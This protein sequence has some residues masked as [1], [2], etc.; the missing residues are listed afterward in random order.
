MTEP[1]AFEPG[2][3]VAGRYVL[4]EVIGSGGM[5]VVYRATQTALDREV[6]IKLVRPEQAASEAARRRFLREA[7]VAASLDHPGAVR[8]HDFGEHENTLYIVMEMLHGVPLRALVDR[9]RPPLEPRRA[10]H[11][12]AEIADVLASAASIDLVHR[13]L[14]PEN[15]ILE[16]VEGSA[17]RVVVVDFGLAFRAEHTPETGRITVEGMASGTPDYMSPEQVRGQ[18]CGPAADVYALGCVLY[19]MLTSHS[20]L[21]TANPALTLT[22]HLFTS[23]RP[24]REAFPELGVP[25]IVDDLVMA[26]L[27][28]VPSERPSAATVRDVLRRAASGPEERLGGHSAEGR[29]LGRVARMLSERPTMSVPAPT[30]G[31]TE[32]RPMRHLRLVGGELDLEV[33]TGLLANGF[34]LATEREPYDACLVLDGS[35]DTVR[36][37]AAAGEP[38]VAAV[39]HRT[40]AEQLADYLRAGAAAVVLRPLDASQVVRGLERAIRTVGRRA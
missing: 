35:L 38:V 29:P 8:I 7:R 37:L 21:A 14:K 24:M 36:R 1:D 9:D 4:H 30:A 10:C 18:P 26:M 15:V 28:K 23:P 17:P 40:D 34:G 32:L 27:S 6:A 16:G 5:G 25:A 2:T 13:D 31:R 20:P 39:D 12:G 22:R 33:L 19:E 11:I 3:L